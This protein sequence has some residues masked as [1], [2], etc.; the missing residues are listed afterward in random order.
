M[1]RYVFTRVLSTVTVV[2]VSG[3]FF[4]STATADQNHHMEAGLSTIKFFS[5]ASWYLRLSVIVFATF[6][7]G[8]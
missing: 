3:R 2:E 7:A 6:S 1:L 4:S 5:L 8:I